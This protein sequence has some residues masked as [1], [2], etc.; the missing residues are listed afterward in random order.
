MFPVETTSRT[1]GWFPGPAAGDAGARPLVCIPYAGGTA[2]VYRGWQER[3]GADIH[4]VPAQLPGRGRRLREPPHTALEPLVTALATA[5]V[6]AE[7][8]HDYV[9]FGHSMGALLAYEV[10]CE[11]R[12]RGEPEPSH[13]FVSGSRAPH[14]YGTREDHLLPDDELRELVSDLGGLDRDRAVDAAYFERRLP[15]LRADLRVCE[16]YRW[17][18]RAPLRCPMTAFSASRDALASAPQTEAWRAYTSG[19]FLRRHLD[20][21][22]F[23]LNG[24]PSR[25]R[26]LRQL[27]DELDHVRTGPDAG[28]QP[29]NARRNAP[30][31]S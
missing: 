6:E 26:L 30:W 12:E 21:G 27:R 25:D 2:S 8:S 1:A 22:H 9:L 20:G 24:G 15:V 7:L 16:T 28:P 19:S 4:V 31:T 23:F 5:L 13:L 18:P 11:L 29:V 10:A 3:L 17:R 14:L